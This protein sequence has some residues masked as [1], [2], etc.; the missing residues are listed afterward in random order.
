LPGGHLEYGETFEQCAQREVLEETGLQIEDAQFST[1]VETVFEIEK[2]HYVTVF[3]TSHVAP[4]TND[5]PQVWTSYPIAMK[6]GLTRM[7]QL[8]EPDKCESWKWM[9]F[10]DVR[11]LE[12]SSDQ[13]LFEPIRSLINQRP[14]IC[15]MLDGR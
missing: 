1:A 14:D 3:V 13:R 15:A 5:E 4:N 2:K 12:E 7:M 9:S 8:L 6:D 11:S 10:D